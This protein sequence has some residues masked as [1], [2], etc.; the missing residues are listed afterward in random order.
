MLVVENDAL[1]RLQHQLIADT[2][3]HVED[4]VLHLPVDDIVLIRQ[5]QLKI[6]CLQDFC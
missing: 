5:P 1:H 6:A 2:K 4:D 3:T